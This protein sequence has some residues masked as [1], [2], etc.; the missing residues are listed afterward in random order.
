MALIGTLRNNMTKW[1]VGLISVALAAFIL[2]GDLFGNGPNSVLGNGNDVGKIGGTTISL[3]EYQAAIQERENNYILN[4][5]RQPGERERPLLQQQAW[6]LLIVQKAIKP[7][8]E[9]VGVRVTSDEIWDMIQGKNIDENV[10]NSFLDSAGNFDRSRLIDYI[11]QFNQP[12]PVEPR[13]LASFQEGKYRWNTFQ[14]DLGLGRER[15]KYEN[16]LLKTNYI[17]EAE[18]E[19]DYHIQNDVAEVK[20]LY[21][22]FFVITDSVSVTDSDLKSYYDRNKQKYKAIETRNLSYVEFSVEASSD[23]S[24][25]I[26]EQMEKFA[27]EFKTVTDDSLYAATNSDSRQAFAKYNVSTLPAFLSNQKE[28]LTSGTI[29]G[30][31]LDQNYYKVV[32]VV[33]V[34]KDTTGVARASHILF[35]WADASDA[36]KKTAK[37]NAKKVLDEIKKGADFAAKAREHGTDGTASQGGDLNWFTS[38]QMV[39]P[40]DKAV[41]GAKKLGLI[42]DLVETQF[43]YHI[44][45]VTGLP[46]YTSYTIATIEVAI[47][48]SDDTQN[49][50]FMKAQNFA[51]ELSGVDDFKE[52]AKKEN[53]QVADANDLT[54]ADRRVNDLGDAREMI[55]WLFRE[56][57]QGE[58]SAV[59][60]LDDVYTVAVMTDETD[61]GFKS[62]NAVK[63]EITPAVLN[64]LRGKKIIEKLSTQKGSLEEMAKL[65]GNDASVNSSSDLK[66]NSN[67]LPAIGLDPIAVGKAFSL[68]NGKTSQPFIGEN[69]VIV[70]ELQNK[71]VAPAVGDYSIFK[72]Q[73]LQS[74]N[75]KSS[76][77]IADA[78]KEGANIQDK[79]YKFF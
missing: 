18:A 15:I 57:K 2:G 69:G 59:F 63:K 6:E 77:G 54:A 38:G 42:N 33:K 65:F 70:I 12:E 56:A 30:P 55:T 21:V 51:T 20:Y 46:E 5:G 17:T 31:F 8:F 73:L 13:A 52:K 16:L 11:N 7:E 26:R 29:I 34:G 36:A 62:L 60:D 22:P 9:K 76:F 53:L 35:R 61:G 32:K 48:P 28:S 64:E 79:R 37:E 41:F 74:Q 25:A 49:A 14:K 50:A 39:G 43:G 3:E 68:E 40:F 58:V 4:F 1:V 72:N 47:T 66:L 45:E 71:T 78:I 27:T 75:G 23:D 67:T 24:L 44:I 19:K 10:K